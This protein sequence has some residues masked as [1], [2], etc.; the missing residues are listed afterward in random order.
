MCEKSV[1]NEECADEICRTKVSERQRLGAVCKLQPPNSLH[2]ADL[3]PEQQE[4][5][6]PHIKEE[7]AQELPYVKE[8]EDEI[9]KFP[10]PAVT[11]KSEDVNGAHCAGPQVDGLLAPLSDS[12]DITSHSS[13]NDA[14][15]HSTAPSAVSRVPGAEQNEDDAGVGGSSEV[16]ADGSG[17]VTDRRPAGRRRVRRRGNWQ[18][19]NAPFLDLQR[20]GFE[21][22]EQELGTLNTHLRSLQSDVLPLLTSINGTLQQI[23]DAAE[24]LAPRPAQNPLQPRRSLRR[25]R[26]QRV[27]SGKGGGGSRGTNC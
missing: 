15:E 20:G 3:G 23:A 11:V 16:T 13:D 19:V 24:Q 26:G 7:D 12:D 2:A 4:P 25:R 17:D 6:H 9:T 5:K 14:D 21:M 10:S 27:A 18:R 1:K 22:L 8:H